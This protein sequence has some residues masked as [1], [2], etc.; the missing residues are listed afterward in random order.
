M[1]RIQLLALGE[2]GAMAPSG[3]FYDLLQGQAASR[4]GSFDVFFDNPCFADDRLILSQTNSAITVLFF[5][6]DF[7]WNVATVPSD[8][9]GLPRYTSPSPKTSPSLKMVIS[10]F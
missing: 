1:P 4:R 10:F 2:R 8:N 9:C 3:V 6:S 5:L 7:D